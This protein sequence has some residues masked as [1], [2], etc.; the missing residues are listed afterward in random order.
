MNTSASSTSNHTIPYSERQMISIDQCA[1]LLNCSVS[2]IRKHV[3]EGNFPHPFKFSFGDGGAVKSNAVR[4]FRSE[5]QNWIDDK[6]AEATAGRK[7]YMKKFEPVPLTFV[8]DTL[9]AWTEVINFLGNFDDCKSTLRKA[10][11]EQGSVHHERLPWNNIRAA[12]LVMLPSL[13]RCADA[14]GVDVE[15]LVTVQP[16]RLAQAGQ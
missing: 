11:T 8:P 7:P 12:V 1:D 3:A 10:K 6:I 5:V 13:I 14:L 2:H 9:R 4:F 16:P 15:E